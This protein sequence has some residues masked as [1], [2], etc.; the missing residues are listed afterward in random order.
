MPSNT[1]KICV[2]C[3]EDCSARPRIKDGQGRYACKACAAGRTK[4]APIPAPV[5]E[6]IVEDDLG[7]GLE[8]FMDAPADEQPALGHA[9][10]GC[11]A[12]VAADCVMCLACGT[13]VKTGKSAMTKIKTGEQSMGIKAAGAVGGAVAT[14]IL[15]TLGGLIGGAIGATVWALLRGYAN[16]ELGIVAWGVGILAGVGVAVGSMGR[17]GL[18]PGVWAALVAVVC[19]GLGKLGGAVIV[20]DK[21]TQEYQGFDPVLV[22]LSYIADEV[23]YEWEYEEGRTLEWPNGMDAEEAMMDYEYWPTGYPEDVREETNQRWEAFSE[24]ERQRRMDET[25]EF[26]QAFGAMIVFVND[27]SLFDLLWTLFAV[28]S[29]FKIGAGGFADD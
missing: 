6:P 18:L 21:I 3:H 27:F 2:I 12:P 9:C 7:F 17:G 14:P 8:D 15:W 19:I 4:P 10:P 24:S 22:E 25:A 23:V 5:P 26:E 16:I 28:L 29:A 20:A 1:P 13:N 11:G